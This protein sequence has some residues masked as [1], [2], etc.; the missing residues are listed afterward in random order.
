MRTP[1]SYLTLR[2]H[3]LKRRSTRVPKRSRHD[4]YPHELA[5]RVRVPPVLTHLARDVDHLPCKVE[6]LQTETGVR[7]CADA[8][9]TNP[10]LVPRGAHFLTCPLRHPCCELIEVEGVLVLLLFHVRCS[11]TDYGSESLLNIRS[12]LRRGNRFI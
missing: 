11:R 7:Q 8:L 9:E 2:Q 6:L 5:V 4:T 1:G 12:R 3:N 10:N